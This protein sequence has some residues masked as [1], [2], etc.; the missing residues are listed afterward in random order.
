MQNPPPNDLGVLIVDDDE[1]PRDALRGYLERVGCKV[2][3]ADG[4]ADAAR[5]VARGH[6]GVAFVDSGW[7]NDRGLDIISQLAVTTPDV[8]IVLLTGDRSG[9]TDAAE[10]RGVWDFLHKPF[11]ATEVHHV[12]DRVIAARA[13]RAR[14]RDLRERLDLESP[15]VLLASRAPAMQKAVDAIERAARSDAPV[16]LRGEKGTGKKLLAW[17]L[18]RAS[19]RAERSFFVVSCASAA[20]QIQLNESLAADGGVPGAVGGTLFLDEVH[21]LPQDVQAT[22]VSRLTVPNQVNRTIKADGIGAD[23]R[24]I[25]TT[26]DDLDFLAREQRIRQDLVHLLDVVEVHVPPL[27]ERPGDIL[28]LA[29]H[30]LEFFSRACGRRPPRIS[31][32]TEAMLVQHD[33]PGN[34]RELRN[35]IER[36]VLFSDAEVLEPNAFP[37]RIRPARSP[38]AYLGGQFT[39]D[40]IERDHILGVIAK[41]STLDEAANVLG[42][43]TST[44]WRKRKRYMEHVT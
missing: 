11:T 10:R 26:S 20:D 35:V 21:L 18:H 19:L 22:L 9:S 43:D 31:G 17:T 25:A 13:L 8:M 24:I 3:V 37:D 38:L 39:L 7:E 32:A 15:P 44:L 14:A 16:L 1:G 42:I 27:R 34:V 4:F 33:W 5:V 30:F 41:A 36:A 29:R 28:S 2:V 12:L 6:I 40:A 23:V